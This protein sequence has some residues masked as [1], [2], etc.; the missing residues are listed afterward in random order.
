MVSEA[1]FSDICNDTEKVIVTSNEAE[2]G[3]EAEEDDIH[4]DRSWCAHLQQ[5]LEEMLENHGFHIVVLCL[6]IIDVI[7]VLVQLLVDH[8]II[9]VHDEEAKEKIEHG[10]HVTSIAILVIFLCEL[11]L[12]LYVYRLRFFKKYCELFDG[13][14]V[15]ISFILDIIPTMG[16]T[17]AELIIIARL[18]RVARIVNGIIL[19]MNTAKEEE[20]QKLSKK[21]EILQKENEELRAKLKELMEE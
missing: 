13:V 12:K 6:V 20:I 19:T 2:I 4:G 14:V 17:E 15:V 18:W 7:I 8:D 1:V 10:L 5:H 3:V 11:F 16:T 21:N 9:K